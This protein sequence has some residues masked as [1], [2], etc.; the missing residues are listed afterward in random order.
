MENNLLPG[1]VTPVFTST[2]KLSPVATAAAQRLGVVI[3]QVPLDKK[4][5]MIKCNVNQG[6]KIYHLPFD[7][8]YDRV[9]IQD[10]AELYVRTVAEAEKKGFRRA[11]RYFGNASS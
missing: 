6:N 3:K 4:Y 7:Q 10:A 9:K 2:T 5:P 11:K 8:Q 1:L